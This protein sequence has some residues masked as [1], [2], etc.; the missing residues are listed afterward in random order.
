LDYK[1]F[2]IMKDKKMKL[3]INQEVFVLDRGNSKNSMVKIYHC[4]VSKIGTKYF[5]VFF[6][7]AYNVKNRSK[8]HIINGIQ[9]IDSSYKLKVYLSKQ[10]IHDEIEKEQ[11]VSFLLKN[12]SAF[13]IRSFSLKALR[14]IKAAIIDARTENL[15]A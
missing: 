10:E 13:E 7:E 12:H 14:N 5:K 11:L 3:E 6:G 15:T 8:F 9:E 2:R 1:N 4:L